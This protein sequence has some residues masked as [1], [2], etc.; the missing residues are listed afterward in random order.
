MSRKINAA[1]LKRFNGLNGKPAYVA[2]KGKVYDVSKVFV[3]GE[4]AGIKA[5][6]DLTNELA[7]GPHDETIFNNFPVVGVLSGSSGPAEWI[8]KVSNQ[9][10]DLILRMAL[11][12]VFFAHGA[13]KLLGWFGGYGWQGTIGFFTQ[14]LQIPASLASLSILVEFFGGIAIILGLFTRPAALAL[15]V[16]MLAAVGKV[17]L[18]NGFFLDQAGPADGIEFVFILLLMSLYFTINGAGLLS[19]DK[20]IFN[21]NGGSYQTRTSGEIS[22]EM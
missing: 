2:F 20:L 3:N 18:A 5:G 15:T 19:L 1:E 17:H 9:Q 12:I 13:Q 6:I 21:R 10:I 22:P 7:K 14:S 16:N 4:H 8:F 11:G